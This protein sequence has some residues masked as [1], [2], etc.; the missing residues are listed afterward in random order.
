MAR[1][2][3]ILAAS[4]AG[5]D[6]VLLLILGVEARRGEGISWR[7]APDAPGISRAEDRVGERWSRRD[8]AEKRAGGTSTQGGMGGVLAGFAEGS[9]ARAV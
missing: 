7:L 4:V 5:K 3:F 2:S 6:G 8:V 1:M 9:G